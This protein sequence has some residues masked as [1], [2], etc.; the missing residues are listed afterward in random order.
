MTP[1]VRKFG[2]QRAAFAAGAK[3]GGD[4]PTHPDLAGRCAFHS[5]KAFACVGHRS[6]SGAGLVAQRAQIG[7]SQVACPFPVFQSHSKGATRPQ[8][9]RA[10][11]R[12]EQ[13]IAR[14]P[15]GRV[16]TSQVTPWPHPM[17]VDLADHRRPG[18]VQEF[19]GTDPDRPS[20]PSGRVH[21]PP[22]TAEDL[23]GCRCHPD[24]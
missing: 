20:N 1:F 3:G 19:A 17:G 13:M 21:L 15:V 2:V 4:H 12:E 23:P 18:A 24:R 6:F 14:P 8:A 9:H 5:S 22:G 10:R 16:T 11:R 7:A